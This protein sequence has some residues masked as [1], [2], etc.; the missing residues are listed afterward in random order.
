MRLPPG[1]IAALGFWFW[2]TVPGLT[3]A[4]SSPEKPLIQIGVEVV[5]VDE[6]KL[7]NLG[8]QWLDSLRVTERDVPALLT[9]GTLT[10]DAV[11]ADLRFMEQ[12]GAADLLANPKLVARDGTDATLHPGGD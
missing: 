6:L 9:L 5:E 7:Q 2:L 10:R 4:A 8:V 11:F 3:L 1:C 12:E